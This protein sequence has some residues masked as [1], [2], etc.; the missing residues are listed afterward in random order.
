MFGLVGETTGGV[1]L[2]GAE[3]TRQ[4]IQLL[5]DSTHLLFLNAKFVQDCF[6]LNGCS[7]AMTTKLVVLPTVQTFTLAMT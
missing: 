6:G 7:L 5:L 2:R 3:A 4:S 1:S